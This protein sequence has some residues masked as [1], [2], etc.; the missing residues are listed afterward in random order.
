MAREE[1]NSSISVT[2]ILSDLP[3]NTEI[4]LRFAEYPICH[5]V[6]FSTVQ[7]KDK[8]FQIQRT[9]ATLLVIVILLAL[10]PFHPFVTT[11]Y[12]YAR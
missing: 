1:G 8:W 3:L 5:L 7:R 9:I 2:D 11:V 10:A 6:T 12:S 4:I